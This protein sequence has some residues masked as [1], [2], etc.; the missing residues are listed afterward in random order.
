MHPKQK[1]AKQKRP[2]TILLSGL[3]VA[4]AL[5][6][7]T[8][9]ELTDTIDLINKRNPGLATQPTTD[10]R[11]IGEATKGEPKSNTDSASDKNEVS[12]EQT[13]SAITAPSGNFVSNHHP[14]LDGDPAPN[15]MQSTCITTAGAY[16]T[17]MFTKGSTTIGLPTQKTD[18]EGAAYWSWGLQDIDL[19]TG[20]WKVQAKATSGSLVEVADDAITLEVGE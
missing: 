11:T 2:R 3:A 9:L 6:G 5:L 15:S 1:R 14:N 8:V 4:I 12:S 7:F 17:I 19:T 10:D 20:S 13:L 18:R 16:C